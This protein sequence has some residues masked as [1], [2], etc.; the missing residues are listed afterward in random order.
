MVQVTFLTW[1]PLQGACGILSH[2]PNKTR[3]LV[4]MNPGHLVTI[5]SWLAANVPLVGENESLDV[6]S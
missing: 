1:A 2:G 4:G 6:V 3:K 5:L